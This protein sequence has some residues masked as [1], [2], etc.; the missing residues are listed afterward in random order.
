MKHTVRM[1]LLLCFLPVLGCGHVSPRQFQG[2]WTN[3]NTGSVMQI[4]LHNDHKAVIQLDSQTDLGSWE[5][6]DD[7]IAIM[8]E[9][10]QLLGGS[11]N[12]AVVLYY[13]SH[14]VN[15]DSKPDVLVKVKE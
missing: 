1:A 3:P 12:D 10:Y 6:D 11:E 14:P 7:S 4:E 13:Y 5:I 9:K 15:P 8:T 2:E